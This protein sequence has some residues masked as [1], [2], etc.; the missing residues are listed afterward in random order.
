M[1]REAGSRGHP[2][3]LAAR[4][5]EPRTRGGRS[6]PQVAAPGGPKG[7]RTW[8][9]PARGR[10]AACPG[11]GSASLPPPPAVSPRAPRL[12]SRPGLP[13][14][15]PARVFSPPVDYRSSRPSLPR[16]PPPSRGLSPSRRIIPR[17]APRRAPRII[18]APF[19]VIPPPPDLC[20]AR[21]RPRPSEEVTHPP[22]P[23]ASARE[24]GKRGG[25]G[26]G[27]VPVAPSPPRAPC[28]PCGR[29][30]VVLGRYRW[31]QSSAGRC[32]HLWAVVLLSG[33]CRLMEESPSGAALHGDVRGWVVEIQSNAQAARQEKTRRPPGL[34]EEGCDTETGAGRHRDDIAAAQGSGRT[35]TAAVGSQ[36]SWLWLSVAGGKVPLHQL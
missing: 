17:P 29:G 3:R 15:T 22:L 36:G 11:A 4:R 32:V 19:G 26:V 24:R 2:A 33:R 20:P 25:S 28:E 18:R 8:Q 10:R 13:P 7:R 30:D 23:S 9:R 14:P 21:P 12:I 34:L 27:R 5:R 35:W 16:D 1:E 31:W 6:R